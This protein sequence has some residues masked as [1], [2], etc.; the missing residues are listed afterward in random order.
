MNTDDLYAEVTCRRCGKG[1]LK[2]STFCPHCGLV[3][4]ETWVDRLRE[5]LRGGSGQAKEGLSP[6][7]IVALAMLAIAGILA[8]DAIVDGRY[9]DL[10]TVALLVLFSLRAFFRR[11]SSPSTS[12]ERRPTSSEKTTVEAGTDDLAT[13]YACEN[14]GTQVA[15]DA[16]QCPKC[17]MRFA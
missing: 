6:T 2:S 10:I 3:Q 11:K 16:S 8:V 4:E 12:P 15:A 13:H 1:R 17:G 7:L 5:R 9:S 14:C